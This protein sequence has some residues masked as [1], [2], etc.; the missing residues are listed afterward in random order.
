[1]S[2]SSQ[3]SKLSFQHLVETQLVLDSSGEAIHLCMD[4]LQ[5]FVDGSQLLLDGLVDLCLA[6][7][8][9]PQGRLVRIERI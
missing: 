7:D 2:S 6:I 1:M 3:L 5:E 4:S 8:K 9:I